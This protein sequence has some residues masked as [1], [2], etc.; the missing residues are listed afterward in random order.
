M[1]ELD[2][3][4]FAIAGAAGGL[5]PTVARRLA[6]DGASLAL[7]DVVQERLDGLVSDLGLP[8]DRIDARVVDLLD[9][10]AASG[11]AE[12]LRGR[13]GQVDGLLHLVG[14]WRGGDPTPTAPPSDSE[15][16]HDLLVHTVQPATRAFWDDLA[17]SD[18]GRFVLLSS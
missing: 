2:G 16:L 13:F 4:T 14:G 9:S 11:W 17:G 5:G 7:T 3:R 15:W 6:D 18:H 12:A 1:A 8:D 10:D